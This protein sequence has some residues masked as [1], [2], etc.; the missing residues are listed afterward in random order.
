[1]KAVAVLIVEDNLGDV[2]LMREALKESKVATQLYVVPDVPQALAFLQDHERYHDPARPDVI[3]VDL[4]LPGN[5]GYELLAE[6]KN[7]PTLAD[8]PIVIFTSSLM[9]E[10]RETSFSLRAADYVLKPMDSTVYF[11]HVQRIVEHWGLSKSLE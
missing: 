2:V 4:H 6:V 11:D 8:I 5:T 1:M 3:V 7:T 9:E 10:D